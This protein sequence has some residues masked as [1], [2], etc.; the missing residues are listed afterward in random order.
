MGVK[1]LFDKGYSLKF[2]KNKSRDAIRE[3]L[4]S[5]RYIDSY[6]EKQARFI[7][8]V[9]F[10]TA[11]N[12]ARFGL[13]EEYYESSIK[14]IYE[15]Y[16]YDGSRAEKIEWENSSNYLDLFIFEHEY[17]RTNG[18]VTIN[19]GSNTY[20]STADSGV[21]TIF[22]SSNPQYIFIKGGPH[23][24]PGGDFKSD[25]FAG[26]SKKG[27]SKANIYHTASQRTNNLEF[28]LSKG[29]TTEFWMKKN[30]W[31]GGNK[32]EFIFHNTISGSSGAGN[33]G[34][35]HLYINGNSTATKNNLYITI[36]SGS[37][38]SIN[39][40]F[41]TGLTDIADSKWHHYAITAKDNIANLYVD[42][43]HA[44]SLSIASI[45]A[46]D[47]TMIASI[48]S[49]AGPIGTS[50][51][52]LGWGNVVATS[53][54]EFRY[55]KTERDGQQ[56]G[57]Y[58]RDQVG[59]GTNTDN[60]KYD[61][62]ANFVDLGVYYKFNEGITEN[63]T[64]DSIILD[65]SGR[66]SNGQFVNYNSSETRNI[67][68]AMVQSGHA[69][70]EFKDPII[71][72]GHPQV[73]ALLTNKKLSGSFHD[74]QNSF[75]IYRSLPGWIAEE[76][77]GQ[78]K[79]LKYLTQ[80]IA[81]FFDDIYLQIQKL[82]RLKDINYPDD[83][84]YEKPLP[85]ADRLLS[86][87]GYDA[88]E[89][90]AHAS[91]LAKYL[92]RD[93]KLLFEKKLYEIKNIIY[94]NIYNNL[95][96][97]QKSKGTYKSL[98]N[99]LRCY[100]IDEELI[101]LNIYANNDTYEFKNN[102]T[103][104]AVRKKY[105]DFDDLE[106]RFDATGLYTNSF[107]ANAYQYYDSTNSNSLSYVP[108]INEIHMSGAS[109]TIETEVFFPKREI[110]DD[111]NYSMFQH[112]TSSI[113]GMHAVV[114]SN[115]DL[116]FAADDK[117]NFNIVATKPDNDK[118]NVK[119]GLITSGSGNVISDLFSDDTYTGTYDNEKWTLAF[120]LRPTKYPLADFVDDTLL[121]PSSAYTYEFY[122]VN[123]LS[124]ILQNEFVVSGTMSLANAAKFFASNKR[125]FVGAA[126][127]DFI[128][129]PTLYS[130][131][132][133]SSTR[134]WYSYLDDE[135]I[136]AH[137]RDASSFG[138]LNPYRNS[139]VAFSNDQ[140]F[141]FSI[142]QIDTLL[143]HWSLDNVTGSNTNGQIFIADVASGSLDD[144]N[145][146]RYGWFSDV[147]KRNY[148]ARGDFFT[149]TSGYTDQAV[150]VE[151][152]QTAKQKLPE[153]VNSDDM[154]KILDKQ[155]DF[156]FTRDTTYVQHLLSVEKSMYQIISEEML[157]YFAT[158]VDFNNL[159][160]QP[161]NRYRLD[162]KRMQKLRQMFF[163]RVENEPDLEK[164][165][166]YFKWVD[167]AITI[168]IGQLIP[169]SA[170]TVELLRNMVESHVLERNKYLTKFPTM[171]SSIPEPV[172][173]MH[174]IE[175]LKYNWR[176]GHAPVNPEQNTNQNTNCLWWKERAERDVVL[177]S[178]NSNIDSNK[179]IILKAAV[180]EVSSSTAGLIT[181]DGVVYSESYYPNRSLRRPIDLVVGRSLKLK[182]GSNS[183]QENRHDVYKNIIKW[184]SDDDF[185]YIDMDNEEREYCEDKFKPDEINK[186]RLK[187][188]ALTMTAGETIDSKYDGSGANDKLPTDGKASLLLPFSAYSSSVNTGYQGLYSDQFNVDFT[189]AH[190]D[191]YGN[192]LEIPMQGPFTDQH[193][194]GMQHRHIKL[195][196]GSD[197]VYTRPEGWHLQEFLNLSSDEVI[198]EESFSNATT[199]RSKDV[200]ILNPPIGSTNSELDPTEYWKNGTDSSNQ[201]TFLKG[202]TPSPGTGPAG[203]Y[204]ATP[205]VNSPYAYCEV[206]PSKVG[207]TF[208]LITPLIDLLDVSDDS[209][210][211][212][213]FGY[214]MH[215]LGI[216]NLRIQACESPDFD[217]AV[218]DLEVRWG[219]LGSTTSAVSGAKILSGQQ[220]I[221]AG[222]N[223]SIAYLDTR[224]TYGGGLKSWL[225]RR[226]YIR[227]LYT[228]GITHLGD[229][230]IDLVKIWK[231]SAGFGTRQNS[232]K[233]LHPTFDDHFNRPTAIFTRQSYAKR[234]VN[235]RNIHM[236]GNSPTTPDINPTVAGNY[237]NR[238]E[239]V[240]TTS[241]EANDPFFVKNSDQI[242]V[243]SSERLH[244]MKI[245]DLLNLTTGS[246]SR[247]GVLEER[248][249][250][251]YSDY[252]L[253]DRTYV[254]GTAKNKTRI[255]S[256]FST[257][258]F[259]TTSRGFLDPAHETY[260]V[261]NV[262][263]FKN[264]SARTVYNSQLQAHQG[265]YGV[266]THNSTNS[267]VYGSEAVGS[268]HS[269]DYQL[270]GDASKHKYHRNNVE[271][272]E[273]TGDQST[274][275]EAIIV[276]ASLHDNGFIS[277]MIPRTDQQTRWI[278]GSII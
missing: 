186:K 43:Q 10:S 204:G 171:E 95:V 223:W 108:A 228:A 93:E 18:F 116:S 71:Y 32:D 141:K 166:E 255:M 51:A 221:T 106:T 61:D 25:F 192:D 278:T 16:P 84:N 64:D 120:R 274:L 133:V 224:G 87:R 265:L 115:T 161:V 23:P 4:E 101:K 180:T 67:Q 160:G 1:D 247:A 76:D 242:H 82:P 17:P 50:D 263:T 143:F 266:S 178:G 13:A 75:S 159:V 250:F 129:E 268:I 31:V 193:V 197:T 14:R 117:I 91:A 35:F 56:I 152:V 155:D 156:V 137:A 175:E 148:P 153:V 261:Y 276:T 28:D 217:F 105:L 231:E 198:I 147:S 119:F 244:I 208:S 132:K 41:E 207:Q 39:S 113:M 216:G 135:T 236:T 88:P 181:S 245:E 258:G 140:L 59:G 33:Y 127:N 94:Q 227:F 53:F 40:S 158:I 219:S 214:H 173:T 190:D 233:L 9:D 272:I 74:H 269:A 237:L 78:S 102:F 220:H 164:F 57:R 271:R 30:S 15:T 264:L 121:D 191:K 58:W 206:L 2:L 123:Y 154:V 249:T 145:N 5:Y 256:R 100:G 52:T 66:I 251:H 128:G 21:A 234:P 68:S 97:I 103:N 19:S 187:L 138:T 226:F 144:V 60:E 29:V 36:Q 167:D 90:F 184:A 24:D 109:M 248:T 176:V 188:R 62:I 257:P 260:S 169:A 195:N 6:A 254:S 34:T 259:E 47:G 136:R 38:T 69:T 179:E 210:I 124:N 81:N 177:S 142:P 112:T 104:T 211:I 86:S 131:V 42:G 72:S 189:N 168:M 63:R 46:M 225:G 235:I 252:T 134:M 118:R 218:E 150:D 125:V 277:H 229:C 110:K 200:S 205:D 273:F 48:G 172:S 243:T 130:D 209:W 11:S 98:R 239:Y 83:N 77:E 92:E 79:H 212:M 22:N 111:K 37:T 213:Q 262:T 7:P 194:G 107:S 149:T 267:R 20:T 162:Y 185:I 8:D 45:N 146:K 96:Y 122:G 80:I 183:Q 240:N 157:K 275:E 12:F 215:G 170:N 196:Q 241:P 246:L 65:Y 99:F 238:Y 201:W 70:K 232:F 253:P 165:I 202:P 54:D 182:G 163:E 126:R 139:N 230:A 49:L 85:F 151:Y 3:D 222:T 73:S 55:W 199:I 89:L 44:S 203:G 114:A 26:P 27:V 174:A 270:T